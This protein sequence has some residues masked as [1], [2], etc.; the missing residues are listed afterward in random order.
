MWTYL[1]QTVADP[2]VGTMIGSLLEQYGPLGIGLGVV[3]TIMMRQNKSAQTRIEN[4]ENLQEKQY[5]AHIAD[6]KEM[7]NEYVELVRNK[8]KVLAD[9]TGCLKAIKDTLERMERKGQ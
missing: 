2:N 8:T 7:I 6:Q 5:A 4:L 3:L 1:A 9:L